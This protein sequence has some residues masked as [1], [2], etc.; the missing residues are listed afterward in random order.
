[1]T[2]NGAVAVMGGGSWGT[3]LTVHLARVGLAPRLWVRAP[4]LVKLMRGGRENP[5]Y[6]PGIDL[7]K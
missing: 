5:W 3:A 6:L 1:M 7:P 2:A 4:E